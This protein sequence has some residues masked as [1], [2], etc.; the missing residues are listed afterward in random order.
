MPLF[1][2]TLPELL[3]RAG[4]SASITHIDDQIGT[5]LRVLPENTIVIFTSD[6]GE[7]NRLGGSNPP[8]G[9]QYLTDGKRKF[10]REPG[11]G[12]ELFFDP[13]ADPQERQNLIDARERAE[14]IGIWRDRL[15]ERLRYSPSRSYC[16]AGA[17]W[18]ASSSFIVAA[19]SASRS[20]SSIGFSWAGS[21]SRS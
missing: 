13:E 12:R 18:R 1:D 3:S 17:S 2:P 14:E 5:L 10:I 6:H 4:Y 9:M 16:E 20:G 19:S 7:M 15:V 11:V 8:T 21:V